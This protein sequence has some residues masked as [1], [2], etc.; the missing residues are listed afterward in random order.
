VCNRM[1]DALLSHHEL[2]SRKVKIK[3]KFFELQSTKEIKPS[4]P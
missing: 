1:T 3:D 4:E 2:S